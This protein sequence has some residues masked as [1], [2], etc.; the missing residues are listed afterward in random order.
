MNL[1]TDQR[2]THSRQ[3]ETEKP[4]TS[5][6]KRLPTSISLSE[7]HQTE[8][9]TERTLQRIQNVGLTLGQRNRSFTPVMLSTKRKYFGSAQTSS[10]LKIPGRTEI[11]RSKVLILVGVWYVLKKKI[12]C[13]L[14]SRNLFSA[15]L[16]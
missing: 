12:R 10:L 5:G 16:A 11:L 15:T 4:D 3:G 7:G 13:R 14:K 9:V 1:I 2:V 8:T 6:G